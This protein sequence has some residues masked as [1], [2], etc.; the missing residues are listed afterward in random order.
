MHFSCSSCRG[1]SHHPMLCSPPVTNYT[2]L[3]YSCFPWFFRRGGPVPP[4]HPPSCVTLVCA[5]HLGWISW[6]GGC[7]RCSSCPSQVLF[8]LAAVKKAIACTRGFSC[9]GLFFLWMKTY[10]SRALKVSAFQLGKRTQ[11][12]WLAAALNS[13]FIEQ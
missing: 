8:S 10:C 12:P 5:M 1:T 7:R 3:S 9:H 13:G 2:E 6:Q 4:E 11:C